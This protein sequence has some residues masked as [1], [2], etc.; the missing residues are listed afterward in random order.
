MTRPDTDGSAARLSLVPLTLPLPL[1]L[2][3]STRS[4]GVTA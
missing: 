2:P 1:P 4:P 3:R